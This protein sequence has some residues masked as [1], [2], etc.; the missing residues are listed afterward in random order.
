VRL[1]LRPYPKDGPKCHE[2]NEI[3]AEISPKQSASYSSLQAILLALEDD[4]STFLFLALSSAFL[5]GMVAGAFTRRI[6]D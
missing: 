5:L 1:S 2:T 6:V 4:L 3:S